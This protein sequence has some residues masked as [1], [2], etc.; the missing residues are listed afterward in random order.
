[1][2]V[3]AQVMKLDGVGSGATWV[4]RLRYFAAVPAHLLLKASADFSTSG[5]HG[6]DPRTY[7]FNINGDDCCRMVR[8]T[9]GHLEILRAV[10]AG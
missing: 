5:C 1:M 7:G 2:K 6:L 3:H 10:T 4:A 9:T 8:D